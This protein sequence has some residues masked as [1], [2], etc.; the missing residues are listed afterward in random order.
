MGAAANAA[1][2]DHLDPAADRVDDLGQ[3]VER[4]AAAVELPSAM[5]RHHDRRRADIDR[6][7][8]ILDRHDA[9]QTELPAPVGADR[10]GRL[11]V[12][13]LVEHGVE[14][15]GDRHRH[16]RA[17]IDMGFEIGQRELAA[18]QIV[19]RPAGMRREAR[20]RAR[21][22]PRRRAEPGPPAALA[23]AADDRV[24][25]QRDGIELGRLAALDHRAVEA[26]V[27]VDVELEQLG[28]GDRRA[29]LLDAHRR[30]AG[31]AEPGIELHRRRA[32]RAFAAPMEQ[33]LQCGR[34]EEQRHRHLLAHQRHRHVDRLDP[35]EHARHQ[36]AVV[37][38]RGVAC[39]G[40][41]V[42]GR[43]V[44]IMEH[45]KGQAPP[46]QFTKI[47]DIA[48]IG[49]AHRCSSVMPHRNRVAPGS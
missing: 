7:L 46:R 49:G 38:R 44:D 22:Q 10:L 15:I 3:L 8:R 12:H 23:I 28:A 39:L 31:D 13:R 41:L 18:E 43:A 19:E 2:A 36:I 4:R 6:A 33:P 26:L 34:R 45:R 21:R 27:L 32:D 24:D 35:G 30:Q 1:V 9:L 20:R 14:I 40:Q 47:V 42:V 37:E 29:D 16:L 11:P 25:G 5:V 48:A 17:G